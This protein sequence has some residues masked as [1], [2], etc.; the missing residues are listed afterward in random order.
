LHRSQADGGAACV[1]RTAVSPWRR[2][3]RFD[4]PS[5]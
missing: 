1:E 5:W 4:S 2:K 3:F